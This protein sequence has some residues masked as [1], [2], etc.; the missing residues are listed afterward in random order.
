MRNFE[1][2]SKKPPG[3]LYLF[4]DR[5]ALFDSLQ[6]VH[7]QLVYYL[8]LSDNSICK[9]LDFKTT[10]FRSVTGQE[11]SVHDRQMLSK[12]GVNQ[13]DHVAVIDLANDAGSLAETALAKKK[14]KKVYV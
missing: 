7:P 8:G 2:V 11:L 13:E 14:Q 9:N 1:S 5:T 10:L 6:E 3:R 12:L 4:G